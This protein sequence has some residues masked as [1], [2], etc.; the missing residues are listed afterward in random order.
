MCIG[1]CVCVHVGRAVS[2]LL[3]SCSLYVE[4]SCYAD[5]V[6]TVLKNG[7]YIDVNIQAF[8][9]RCIPRLHFFVINVSIDKAPYVIKK[10]GRSPEN[11][12]PK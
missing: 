6:E 9:H 3:F 12:S 4:I 1:A 10:I 2:C 11:L 8:H 7:K 5:I